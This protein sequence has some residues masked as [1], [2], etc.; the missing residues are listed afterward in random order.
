MLELTPWIFLLPFLSFSIILFF[1]R[2]LPLK[3]AIVG[4]VSISLGFILSAAL[5]FSGVTGHLTLPYLWQVPWF[6]FGSYQMTLGVYVAGETVCMLFVITLVSLLVHIYSLGY[7]H[8]DPRFKRYYAFL[9][10]FTA[11]ML[12]LV[13]ADSLFTLFACWELVGLCS[14]FLIGFWFEKSAAAYAGRKAFIT[15]KL[16]DLG[17]LVGLLLLFSITGTF[18]IP[19]LQELAHGGVLPVG[20]TGIACLLLFCGAMGKS[21]QVPL[22][23]WLPDAMEG[24]TPVS[25][26]I[27]AATMVTAGVFLVARVFF[28]FEI[29]PMVLHV[30]AAVGAIT[31]LCAA[32]M[33]LV[34]EDIKRVLA[35]S[36]V[37][38]LG[39]MMVGMALGGP[40]VGMFHLTTHAMFKAMLFLGAGS[41]IHAVHTNDIWKMGGLRKKMPVTFVTFVIGVLALAG[42]FPLSGFFSKDQILHAAIASGN[43][44]VFVL[45]TITAG[46]TAFYMSRVAVLAFFGEPRDHHAYEHAHESPIAMTLP[47]V[48][49]A[50]PSIFLGAYLFHGETF[51]RLIPMQLEH[52]VYHVSTTLVAVVSGVVALAGIVIAWLMYGARL[53]D[54]E[55]LYSKFNLLWRFLYARMGFDGVWLF[56]VEA[57]DRLAGF[58]AALD[59][60]VLDQGIVDGSGSLTV[61]FSK[62]GRWFDDTIVDNL[63][64][65]WGWLF[66][67]GGN[68]V[69]ASVS[70]FVQN[71]LLY[72]IVGVSLILA[73]RIYF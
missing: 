72:I 56:L 20:L 60:H 25:A 23:V 14:Y 15:T 24:P 32:L 33:G 12:G 38:Q 51:A 67:G 42:I 36:T 43:I 73:F 44:P 63:V 39:Y 62:I 71:Y 48:V 31:A 8:G 37:S 1:G 49:L 59:Y 35:F 27:H 68:L 66:A 4:I 16:G 29:N 9:S 2:W 46:L 41:V 61:L 21:A 30:V 45:L 64:D 28:L 55:S 13:L 70:G 58:L 10:L 5:F 50:V 65:C 57:A 18:S 6:S 17:F 52:E 53:I 69:R 26:L 19:Q 40:Q 11:S 7:M 22:F 47:L 3:G 54:Y 34:P